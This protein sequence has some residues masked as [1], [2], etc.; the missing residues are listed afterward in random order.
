MSSATIVDESFLGKVSFVFNKVLLNLVKELRGKDDTFKKKL[1]TE[2]GTFDKFSSEYIV[3]TSAL[4]EQNPEV[5]L[6][7]QKPYDSTLLHSQTGQMQLIRNFSVSEI[8]SKLDEL[9]HAAIFSY[10]YTMYFM[11]VLRNTV[12]NKQHDTVSLNDLLLKSVKIN[13]QVKVELDDIT[14]N[15]ISFKQ[16][17]QNMIDCNRESTS[18]VKKLDVSEIL[19]DSSEDDCNNQPST[20]E[21]MMNAA[22][23]FLNN[24][25]I[26]ELAKEIAGEV[27][28]SKIDVSNQEKLFDIDAMFSGDNT[29]GIGSMIGT[30]GQKITSKLENGDLDQTVLMN[31][32]L[33]M[34]SK[35]KMDNPLLNSMMNNVMGGDKS[36][37]SELPDMSKFLADIQ[38]KK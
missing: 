5:G 21:T 18:V 6:A 13:S 31:E 25:K 32:A 19:D 16:L 2:Y 30:V 7:L 29:N 22:M 38:T 17:M 26:G 24:S 15:D 11:V 28:F 9:E 12:L 27:D 37:A 36:G 34:M 10:M 1:K 20:Q 33:Q 23:D 35:M 8:L 14:V 3:E 4:F